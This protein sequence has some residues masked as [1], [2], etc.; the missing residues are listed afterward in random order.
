V[1]I[2][3]PTTLIALLRAVAYGWRQERLADSARNISDLGK[4]LYKR[5]STLSEHIAKIG[6]GLS[7]AT[8]AYNSSVSSLESRVLVTVRKF[9]EM[10]VAAEGDL[11]QL[12]PV[13][14]TPRQLAPPVETA[15]ET[16]EQ[17]KDS[18]DDG[19][20]KLVGGEES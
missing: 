17:I 11:P 6:K 9:E 12:E 19:D 13:E 1:I 5:M 10:E 7:S 16:I 15:A 18:S 20:F 8:K 3:T 2:A 14:E 4:E